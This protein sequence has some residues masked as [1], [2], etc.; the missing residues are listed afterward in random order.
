MKKANRFIFILLSCLIMSAVLFLGYIENMKSDIAGSLLRLHIIGADDSE[1]AQTLKIC[2]RDRILSDFSDIF[3]ECGSPEESAAKA[4]EYKTRIES[5]AKDELLR[6]G[7]DDSVTA[8]VEDCRFPTKN[9]GDISLPGGVYTALNIRIG[10]ASGRNWWC[11][12]YPPL[13]INNGNAVI[14]EESRS[15]LKAVLSPDEYRLITSGEQPDIKIKFKIAEI[16][17]RCFR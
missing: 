9:Y 16:L 13:C 10:K 5:A 14:S 15:K 4:E 11:V 17:G 6:H 1:Y 7:C 2:V 8:S 3:S 12:M